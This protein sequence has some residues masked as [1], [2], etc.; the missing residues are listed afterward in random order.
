[1]TSF[2][3]CV[4]GIKLFSVAHAAIWSSSAA[5]VNAMGRDDEVCVVGIL[6]ELVV[7][8]ERLEVGG[9]DAYDAG[10]RLEPCTILADINCPLS[11]HGDSHVTSLI[12]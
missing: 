10:P 4:F 5:C 12:L 7:S 6:N 8:V 2:D 3:L 1:M 11:G 9:S